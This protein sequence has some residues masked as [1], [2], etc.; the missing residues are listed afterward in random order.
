MSFTV[1]RR[2]GRASRFEA[3]S[4]AAERQTEAEGLSGAHYVR[5]AHEERELHRILRLLQPPRRANGAHC[6]DSDRF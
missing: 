3:Q 2:S 5:A 6:R 4:A 1:P